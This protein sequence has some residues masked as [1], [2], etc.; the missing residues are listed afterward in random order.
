MKHDTFWS[1]GPVQNSKMW[2]NIILVPLCPAENLEYL[3]E[4]RMPAL[5]RQ[6]AQTKQPLP[7]SDKEEEDSPD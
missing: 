3:V 6:L 1:P 4:H 2:V 7:E 5:E